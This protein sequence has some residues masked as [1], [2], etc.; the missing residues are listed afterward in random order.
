[1]GNI[2]ITFWGVRGSIAVPGKSTEKFGGNTACVEISA[3]GELIICDA[4]TGMR[5]LGKDLIRRHGDKPIRATILLSHIH[6]DHY[7]G[8]PFFKPLYD[9]KNSFAIC[10]P[11]SGGMD[12]KMAI[13]NAIR[14]PYFPQAITG[15]PS[16]IEFRT[17]DVRPFK[18]GRVDVV[19]IEVNHPGGA[20]GWKFM[21]DGKSV[22]HVSDN[23]PQ[24]GEARKKIVSWMNGADLLIHDAQYSPEEYARHR[25]WGH[26]S[27][28]Y[29]LEL[30]AEANVKRVILFHFDPDADDHELKKRIK[31]ANAWIRDR[32][33]EMHCTLASEGSSVKI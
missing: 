15:D 28:I 14:P 12:F 5:P 25:G 18:I 33:L 31:A 8:L 32:G 4:G 30:A 16:N 9:K 29:P 22:V 1:M 10:G 27:Y 11:R 20:L 7:F 24:D 6:W 2:D 17:I 3:G 23:E 13:E 26:S 19:P 21:C